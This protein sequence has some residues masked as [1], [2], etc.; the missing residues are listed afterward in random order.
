MA[1]IA[2]LRAAQAEQS[3]VRQQVACH[4]EVAVAIG[5]EPAPRQH[6]RIRLRADAANP[7]VILRSDRIT[8]KEPQRVRV[9]T[10]KRKEV[11]DIQPSIP[12]ATRK[13]QTTP[14]GGIVL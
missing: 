3:T 14:N 8:W 1:R 7:G 13:S 4:H 9:R 12:F 10:A 6:K 11:H 5:A 2:L